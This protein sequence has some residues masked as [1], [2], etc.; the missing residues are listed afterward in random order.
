M[1]LMIGFSLPPGRPM[2]SIFASRSSLMVP[3]IFHI[4]RAAF[5]CRLSL[6]AQ[7]LRSWQ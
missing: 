1:Q 3:T 6:F 5:L 7:S 4:S 2:F